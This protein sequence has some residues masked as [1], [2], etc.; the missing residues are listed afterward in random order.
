MDGVVGALS[1]CPTVQYRRPG[2]VLVDSAFPPWGCLYRS[3]GGRGRRSSPNHPIA[4]NASIHMCEHLEYGE[5]RLV[6]NGT[7]LFIGSPKPLFSWW[8]S[9]LCTK[10]QVSHTEG[11]TCLVVSF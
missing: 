5:D 4:N 1:K 6:L 9:D 2:L 11:D 7:F 8:S 3:M 10:V